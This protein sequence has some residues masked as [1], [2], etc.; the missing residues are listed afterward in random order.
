VRSYLI[1]R[2][3]PLGADAGAILKRLEEEPDITIRRALLLSLGE[4]GEQQLPATARQ[5]LLP[6]LQDIYRSDADPGL[7]AS[8]EWLLRH[9]DQ[10]AW[11]K[12]VNEAWAKDKV[13]R[14]QRLQGIEDLLQKDKEKTPPQWYVNGQ[15]QTM[16][17]IPGPVEFLMGS[18][19]TENG[20]DAIR[21]L[22][23]RRRIGR[24][25]AL[26]ATPVTKEQF[27]RFLPK[28]SHKQMHR[29]PYPTCPIGG[30]TWYEAAA[31][32]NWLSEQEGLA[33]EQWCYETD[34][35]GRVVRLRKDY[36][37]L[38]GYRLPTEA[39]WEYACRAGAGTSRCYGEAG[40]LL[41]KYAW[42]FDN[43]RERT[44]PVG[45]TKPNDLG[46]FDVHGNIW[47]W[48]QET[49]RSYP[50][51][52]GAAI[53]DKEDIL[54]IS[55]TNSRVLRGGSFNNRASNVRSAGRIYSVPSNRI[56]FSGFRPSRTLRPGS[57]TAL[58]PSIPE[59]GGTKSGIN[60][61]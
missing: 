41:G 46:L 58:P 14:E 7:H 21:E 52:A 59:G 39:E 33:K 3:A 30:V 8:A 24:T 54:T 37:G 9:W 45:S 16:V 36:L 56:N 1:H 53:E 11:L 48:C 51:V 28:F 34:A 47:N 32:C 19:P 29:Y 10:E 15:G 55:P 43:S 49:Y 40:E 25:F 26:A 12:Q 4:Y 44:W 5:A 2:L 38:T 57:F 23:H 35:Q 27:L 22:Q 60:M 42:Y 31:Y 18:P 6:K 13:G 50:G 20:R 61:K 17:V